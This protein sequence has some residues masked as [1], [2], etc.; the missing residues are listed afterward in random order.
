MKVIPGFCSVLALAALA[1]PAFALC[2]APGATSPA[3][4]GPVAS[5]AVRLSPQNASSTN[6]GLSCTGAILSLATGDIFTGNFTSSVVGTT[7]MVGPTGDVISY[8]LYADSTTAHPISRG[9]DFDFAGT[10]IIS[11]L[12]LI[13]SATPKSVPLYMTSITGSNVAAGVYTETLKIVWKWNY[14]YGIGVGGLCLGRDNSSGTSL[15][16]ISMTVT[17]DCQI[18]TPAIS[19]NSAPVVSGFTPVSQNINISCTK[20]SAYSVGLNDGAHSSGGRRRM[21]SGSNFLAYDI[22]KSAGSIRWG[23]VASARRQSSDAD[24]NPGNGSGAGT[25]AAGSQLFQYN[26]KVYTDQPTPPAGVYG[27]SVILDV[28]F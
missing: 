1:Q 18:I 15:L 8:T 9:V 11:A 26:A 28:A 25:G 14:C 27:D 22:F 6:G 17:N 16:T 23:S 24:V 4:F 20:G 19:F 3:S 10:G 12:G 13:G 7:G 5:M 21:M 2:S